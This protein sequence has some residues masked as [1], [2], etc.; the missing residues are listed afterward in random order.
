M[1]SQSPLELINTPQVIPI[2]GGVG[3]FNR[4]A[5]VFATPPSAGTVTIEYRNLGGGP[6]VPLAKAI[7]LPVTSGYVNVRLD[8]QVAALRVT[9]AGLV[10]GAG[11]ALWS[12]SEA[13]PAGVANGNAALI[14]QPYTEANVKNGLQYYVRANWPLTDTI[15]S[16]E[17]VKLHFQT[18]A[19]PVIVKLR[20][21][22]YVAE[23]III[24]LFVGPTGV[25][26]GEPLVIHNYNSLNGVPST[27]A[28]AKNVTTVTDGVELDGD[29]PETLFG[30]GV[31]PQ[32]TSAAI[33]VG[34][35]RILPPLT[36][37]IVSITNSGAGAA[38]AQYF[39]DW[40]E[41]TPDLPL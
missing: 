12:G 14:V 26:G 32:R 24:R 10:G 9:F 20:D 25:A 7:D 21:F 16:G 23:E 15:A 22:S 1:A 6:W 18:G 8:G 27:C 3:G 13:L 33:P 30:A 39:L 38:R 11:A 19:K 5:V 34:R 28:A 4:I 41:G 35:E 37:F 29:D 40:F 17:T 36:F 2:V 31:A